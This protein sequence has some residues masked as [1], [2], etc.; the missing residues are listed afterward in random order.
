MRILDRYGFLPV[1]ILFACA[2]PIVISIGIPGLSSLTLIALVACA[3]FCLLGLQFG[4]IATEANIYP[5]Y[6]RSWGIAS[7]FAIARIG[8]ALGPLL[9][10]KAFGAR[11]AGAADFC[12]CGGAACGWS[13]RGPVHSAALSCA[14]AAPAKRSRGCGAGGAGRSIAGLG[15]GQDCRAHHE[16]LGRGADQTETCFFQLRSNTSLALD[17]QAVRDAVGLR[18]STDSIPPL[19]AR[20]PRSIGR[21]LNAGPKIIKSTR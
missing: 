1:P 9:G 15:V 16:A 7:N 4:N 8:G 5:T 21:G 17:R 13:G 12:H 20:V 2:I 19:A 18:S 14:A 10:G 6:I 3:G 11:P